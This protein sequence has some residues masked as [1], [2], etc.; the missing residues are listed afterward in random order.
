MAC[1]RISVTGNSLIH[2]GTMTKT[3]FNLILLLLVCLKVLRKMQIQTSKT[4]FIWDSCNLNISAQVQCVYKWATFCLSSLC[5]PDIICKH[6]CRTCVHQVHVWLQA[7]NTWQLIQANLSKPPVVQFKFQAH[8]GNCVFYC[9]ILCIS[10]PKHNTKKV[11]S[12]LRIKNL[13]WKQK[14]IHSRN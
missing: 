13:S 6:K 1:H 11:P 12:L 14:Q 10:L 7:T 2:S 3:H 4:N 5:L 9:Q 8:F